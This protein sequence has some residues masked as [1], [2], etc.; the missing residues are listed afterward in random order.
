MLVRVLSPTT[1]PKCLHHVTVL[2]VRDTLQSSPTV[3]PILA[4]R[5]GL[6]PLPAHWQASVSH[7]TAVNNIIMTATAQIHRRLS[8]AK[9]A[10]VGLD[11][12]AL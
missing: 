7:R 9:H 12:A 8:T 1:T 2:C 11:R 3:T 6:L 10:R 5:P 4:A